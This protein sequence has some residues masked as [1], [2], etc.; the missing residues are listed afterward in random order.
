MVLIDS[1]KALNGNSFKKAVTY[2]Y[3]LP[4]IPYEEY[5]DMKKTEISAMVKE[6]IQKKIDF[7]LAVRRQNAREKNNG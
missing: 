5:K 7:E 6:R 4:T 3:F 2:I 1:Y